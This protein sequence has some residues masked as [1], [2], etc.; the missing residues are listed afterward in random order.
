MQNGANSIK[1]LD[2]CIFCRF[3]LCKSAVQMTEFSAGDMYENLISV[4]L[5]KCLYYFSKW[6][7]S[8]RFFA[9][10]MYENLVAL[11]PCIFCRFSVCKSA[12]QMTEFS[13]G[14]MYENPIN[15]IQHTQQVI[16]LHSGV[17]HLSVNK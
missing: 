15:P 3:S 13:A 8:I 17:Y 10:D 5:A 16:N 2:L 12:V 1:R 7:K 11:R 4:M 9:G 14:N 6:F